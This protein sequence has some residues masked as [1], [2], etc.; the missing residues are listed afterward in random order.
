[1]DGMGNDGDLSSDNESMNSSFT[2]EREKNG[3]F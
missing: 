2:S 3:A 1:M